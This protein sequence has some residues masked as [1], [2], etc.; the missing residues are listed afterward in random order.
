M[1]TSILFI[2]TIILLASCKKDI[3]IIPKAPKLNVSGSTVAVVNADTIPDHAAFKIKLV[4]DDINSDETMIIFNKASKTTY[5]ASEDALYLQG[6]GQEGLSSISSDGRDLVF[7]NLPYTPGM[8]IRLNVRAQ[9]D[10]PFSFQL[11]YQTKV[12]ANT[13]IWLKDNYKKDSVDVRTVNYKFNVTKADTN[14][15]GQNRFKLIIKNK[16][17]Q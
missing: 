13:Q 9:A 10:G 6:F 15:F 4:K 11:S 2:F 5:S 1:K 8:S 16:P 12:P 17:Q 3:E 7:N 14:S